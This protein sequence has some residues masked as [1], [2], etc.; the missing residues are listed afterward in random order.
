MKRGEW[1]PI[2]VLERPKVPVYERRLA[3]PILKQRRRIDLR[4]SRGEILD[5]ALAVGAISLVYLSMVFHYLRPIVAVYILGTVLLAF[6]VHEMAHKYAAINYGYSARFRAT[7]EGLLI[8]AI[9]AL[10]PIKIIAPGYVAVYSS[11]G[12]YDPKRVGIVALVGPLSNVILSMLGIGLLGYAPLLSRFLAIINADIAL[13][14]LLPLPVLDGSKVATW[15]W[16]I[17]LAVFA[18]V[19]LLWFYV[20]FV[21]F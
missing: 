18:P 1:R 15:S 8:T 17:W 12:L 19:V 20:R 11:T 14:N 4:I 16:K 21:L 3:P 9:S 7:K 6:L 10:L 5:I 2:P 13:F